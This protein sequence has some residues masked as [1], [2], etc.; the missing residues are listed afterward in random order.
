M[1][2]LI[3]WNL[4]LIA[5]LSFMGIATLLYFLL[6]GESRRIAFLCAGGFVTTFGII[7]FILPIPGG[8]AI[9]TAGLLIMFRNS[10]WFRKKFVVNFHHNFPRSFSWFLKKVN[11]IVTMKLIRKRKADRSRDYDLDVE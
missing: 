3:N 6:E 9:T 2:D 7:V 1:S 8:V 4:F 10:Q 5:M 11:N